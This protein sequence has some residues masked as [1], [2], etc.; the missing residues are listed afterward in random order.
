LV[1]LDTWYRERLPAVIAWRQP[2]CVELP[3]LVDVVRWK[4][5]RGA[6]RARNLVLVKRNTDAAVRLCSSRAFAAAPDPRQPLQVVAELAGVGPAT[7]SAVLAAHRPDLYPFLDDVVGAAMPELG[8][9]RFT[10]AYYVRYAAALRAR[11]AALGPPWDAQRV[12]LALWAAAGGKA[13]APLG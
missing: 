5:K 2:P 13:A 9:P 3:E 8:E 11:A 12:G 1:A 4:M 10:L 7:A 6:W